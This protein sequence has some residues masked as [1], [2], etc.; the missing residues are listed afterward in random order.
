MSI[1]EIRA[2]LHQIATFLSN[3]TSTQSGAEKEY[4]KFKEYIAQGV[5]SDVNGTRKL[6]NS[7]IAA[8]YN[9]DVWWEIYN[10]A[11][12]LFNK[13]TMNYEANKFR[14]YVTEEY[15]SNKGIS[16]EKAALN[17]YEKMSEHYRESQ[18]REQEKLPRNLPTNRFRGG[19]NR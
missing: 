17:V 13:K 7:D 4:R 2:K 19:G 5:Y 15:I 11:S 10:K 16:I 14:E 6:S 3:K 8:M 9:D 18:R 12:E 1:P